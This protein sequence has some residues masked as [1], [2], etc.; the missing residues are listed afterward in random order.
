MTAV[1]IQDAYRR[2]SSWRERQMVKS[3]PPVSQRITVPD[4]SDR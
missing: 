2:I 1:Q 4:V 3:A